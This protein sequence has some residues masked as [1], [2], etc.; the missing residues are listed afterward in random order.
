LD[1]QVKYFL[2]LGI[3]VPEAA[4]AIYKNEEVTAPSNRITAQLTSRW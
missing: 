3:D 1:A 2:A 4:S